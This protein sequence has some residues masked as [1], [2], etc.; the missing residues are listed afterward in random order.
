MFIEPLVCA[1]YCWT[2]SV[3]NNLLIPHH[4]PVVTFREVSSGVECLLDY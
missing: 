1:K 2:C 4:V 3:C